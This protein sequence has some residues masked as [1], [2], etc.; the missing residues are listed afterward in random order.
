MKID[1]EPDEDSE[2]EICNSD[3]TS[4]DESYDEDSISSSNKDEDAPAETAI[5]VHERLLGLRVLS[6]LYTGSLSQTRV[7]N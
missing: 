3:E 6:S 4:N 2:L 1:S 7:Q 5:D